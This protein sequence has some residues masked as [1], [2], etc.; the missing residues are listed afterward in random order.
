MRK[1]GFPVDAPQ[2]EKILRIIED[3]T[4]KTNTVLVIDDYHNARS[5][6]FDKLVERL[7]HA[8][9]DDSIS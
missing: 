7:V 5:L 1:L 6:E 4:Y 3:L 8:N 2:R 9:I